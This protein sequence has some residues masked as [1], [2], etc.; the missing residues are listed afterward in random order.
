MG[1][2]GVFRIEM[3]KII[4]IDMDAFYASVEQRDAPELRGKPVV[5]GGSP[6]GRGVV[7]AASY[8]ARK[9]GIH[10]A[11]PAYRALK[12]CPQAIFVRPRFERYKEISHQIR[13]IFYAYTDLVEPLSLD[14]AYLDITENKKEIPSAREVAALLK[15]DIR[16]ETGLVASAGVAINKFLAKMASDI[17]KPDGLHVIPPHKMQEYLEQLPVGKFHGIGKAT[18]AKMLK[19]GIK[20]GLDLKKLSEQELRRSFGK[21]G[22]FYFNIVRG[23]DPRPVTPNRIR[24]SVGA[25]NTFSENLE[26]LAEVQDKLRIIAAKVAERLRQAG[27][28]GKTITLKVRYDSFESV[29]RSQTLPEFIEREARIYALANALTEQTQAGERPVRLLGIT[30]SGLNLE[31]KAAGQVQEKIPEEGTQLS[32]T[33]KS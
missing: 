18:E 22:Y 6:T 32:F 2:C 28:K 31:A 1:H 7:A 11:M 30:L 17:D 24:R 23:N 16:R 29:T 21:V 10:S 20:T 27:A 4:H 12:L 25:E 5:V 26:T 3:R 9:F 15:A 14:E 13:E 8:E 33:F 19:R